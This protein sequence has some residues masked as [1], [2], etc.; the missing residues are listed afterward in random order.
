[1]ATNTPLRNCFQN[2][3]FDIQSSHT[4]MRLYSLSLTVWQS[5]PQS[6]FIFP[7]TKTMT[8]TKAVSMQSVCSESV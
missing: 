8:T 6:R 4:K 7:I 3:C 5:A 1:M 2:D